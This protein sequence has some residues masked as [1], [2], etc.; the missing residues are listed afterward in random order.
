MKY[1]RGYLTA[2]VIALFSWLLMDFCA[3]HTILVDMVYPYVSRMIQTFLAQWG[4]GAAFCV[5]QVLLVVLG[6]GTI[7]SIV[8][9]IVLRWNPVQ[10]FGWVLTAVSVLFFLHTGIY[11]LNIYAGAIADDIRLEVTEYTLEELEDAVTYYRDQA[12]TLATKVNRDAA[13][14]PVYPSF[15]ELA[16]QAK[17]GYETLIYEESFSIYAGAME[18]VKELGW[19]DRYTS[20]GILGTTIPLT[21][22]AAVNP[23]APTVSL[24]FV[25]CHEMAHRMCIASDADANLSAYL[26]CRANSGIEFQYSAYF[27][28]YVYSYEALS[29]MKAAEAKAA[30]QR[31]SAGVSDLLYQDLV[32]YRN[33]F[34]GSKKEPNLIGKTNEMYDS[35][36]EED[37]AAAGFCDLLVS[38]HIQEIVLPLQ[39]EQNANRFDPYD[40]SKVDISGIVNAKK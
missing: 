3:S 6:L 37:Y 19:A 16:A 2:A 32:D 39:G 9:M 34:S 23:Q 11:G 8:L 13:G 36:R 24:P 14:K 28:A 31:V 4:S 27:M 18:P 38:W 10:W 26:A 12:N 20:K 1:W 5:W 7:A 30:A 29:G 33:F 25:M 40:E 22:E 35:V 15:R 17:D 21:G